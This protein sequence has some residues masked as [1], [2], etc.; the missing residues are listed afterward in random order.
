MASPALAL[1][2]KDLLRQVRDVKG[3]L[4]YLAAPLMLTLIMGLAFGG[5]VFGKSGHQ[6]HPHRPRAAA[7]CPPTSSRPSPTACRRPACSPSPGRTPRP[8]DAWS[9]GA[10]SRRRWS[11]PPTCPSRFFTGEEVVFRLDSD[12]NSPSRPASSRW[13]ADRRASASTRPARRPTVPSGP[14]PTSRPSTPTP[15]RWPTSSVASPGGCSGPCGTIRTACRPRWSTSWN[16]RWPLPR[17]STNRP[18]PCPCTTA[19]TGAPR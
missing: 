9:R 16:A 12:P 7:T 2:R 11:C 1:I 5:G 13:H 3:L 18:S 19:R 8:P 15:G 6:H 14:R 10:R 4:I 17:P